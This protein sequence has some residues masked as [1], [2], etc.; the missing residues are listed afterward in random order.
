MTNM[1]TICWHQ[2]PK[3]KPQEVNGESQEVLVAV[4]EEVT[5]RRFVTTDWTKRGRWYHTDLLSTDLRAYQVVAWCDFPRFP[6]ARRACDMER[7]TKT[8]IGVPVYIGPRCKYKDTG[9]IAAELDVTTVRE[10]LTRLA[11]YED[12]GLEPEEI[13]GM[14]KMEERSR[15]AKMLRWED[16]EKDGRLVV[17]PCKVGDTVYQTDKIRIYECEIKSIIFET[18]GAAFDETAIGKYVFLTRQEAEAALKKEANN[19]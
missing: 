12:T 9:D 6:V 7:L 8:D 15:M 18:D 11:A 10:V 1:V 3:E 17:L 5:G 16:A 14:C 13:M 2:W 19:G 4:I